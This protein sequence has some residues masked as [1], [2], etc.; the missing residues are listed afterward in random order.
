M[1]RSNDRRRLGFDILSFDDA[2]DSGRMLE[3]E[4]IGLGKFFP[5]YVTANEVRCSDGIADQ[6]HLFRAFDMSR[7]PRIYILHYPGTNPVRPLGRMFRTPL[8]PGVPELLPSKKTPRA[9]S[10]P[11]G[12]VEMRVI[13]PPF[14]NACEP[15]RIKSTVSVAAS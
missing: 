12:G 8:V 7:E 5:I 9:V 14:A 1:G 11:L 10:R 2:D 4:A 3:V 15:R 6:Y 13:L